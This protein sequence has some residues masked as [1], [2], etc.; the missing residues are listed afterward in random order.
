MIELS[1][2]FKPR[3][4]VRFRIVDGETPTTNGFRRAGGGPVPERLT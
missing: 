2:V 3:G 1:C 4:D